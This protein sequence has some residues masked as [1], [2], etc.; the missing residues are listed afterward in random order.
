MKLQLPTLIIVCLSVVLILTIYF[1]G[2][3][4]QSIQESNEE[5]EE[6][7]TVRIDAE[8]AYNA[9]NFNQAIELYE[10]ALEL[11]PE[12][13]EIYNDLGS[14]HYD[15]GL[16]YAGP[17]WPSWQIM[18]KSVE[19]ALAEFDRAIQITESGYIVFETSSTEIAKA[20]EEKAKLKGAAVFPY[21][22]N[23]QTT[24]NIL[25][26]STKD[27]LLQARW[28]FRKSIE[29]K[30]TYAAPYRNIG[31]F[32]MKIGIRD[33]ALNYLREAYKRE[34]SDEVLGEY[35]QQFRSEF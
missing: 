28:M 21:H 32:Y 26:G 15:L 6:F 2:R 4:T 10:Q 25:I 33:K 1:L 16:K 13:A 8:N 5:S 12:N 31:A 19:G 11:R 30:S 23:S 14:T 17:K 3:N 18:D 20:V 9:Q 29:L 7:Q 34:P 24:L 22:G 27:H 35:L